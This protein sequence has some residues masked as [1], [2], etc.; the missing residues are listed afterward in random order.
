MTTTMMMMTTTM[1]CIHVHILMSYHSG[2][3]WQTHTCRLMLM[4]LPRVQIPTAA[5][6]EV[7]SI[8]VIITAIRFFSLYLQMNERIYV[9][10]YIYVKSYVHAIF[11]I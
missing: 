11:Y 5:M 10:E 6:C 9:C 4:C 1:M 2:W 7:Q 3:I 8:I